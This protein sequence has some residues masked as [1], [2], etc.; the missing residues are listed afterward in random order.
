MTD[1]FL[2]NTIF[3]PHH[4]CTILAA[5]EHRR[6]TNLP[7]LTVAFK[8]CAK[9]V[10]RKMTSEA[11]AVRPS[12]ADWRAMSSVHRPQVI[13]TPFRHTLSTHPIDTPYRHSLSTHPIDTAYRH[14]PSTQPIDTPHRHSLSV[15]PLWCYSLADFAPTSLNITGPFRCARIDAPTSVDAFP[16]K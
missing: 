11:F 7:P 12:S 16:T 8:T 6:I 5:A 1:S 10:E 3:P 9:S 13:D 2:S 4:L 14:T 15:Y